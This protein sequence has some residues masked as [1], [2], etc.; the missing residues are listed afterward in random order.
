MRLRSLLCLI[1]SVSATV[2]LAADRPFTVGVCAH[3]GQHKGYLPGNLSLMKQAGIVSFRDE[4]GWRS[5]ERVKGQLQMPPEYE[6][7]ISE[8]VRRGLEPMLILDYGNPF[9]D[10]GDKPLS[11]EAV[12]AFVRYSEFVV[13]HFRGK[14]RHYEVWNEWDIGIG[15]TTPGS[16]ETYAKLLAA[17]YPRIKKADPSI[18]VYGGAMTPGGIRNGW[19]ERMLKAGAL[20]SLDQVSIH[21]YNYSASGRERSPEAWAGWMREVQSL[22]SKYADGK[23]YP[24]VVTEMG[25]PTQVDRRGTPPAVSG[26]Y[27]AR[28]Y[29]LGR[30]VPTL[31]GIWWYDFQDDGWQ[32]K[33]NEDNFGIVRPDLTPKPGYF[34]LADVSNVVGWGAY[35]GR[36]ETKDPDIWALRFRTPDG[37]D[38]LAVWSVHEDDGWQIVLRNTG[39]L[40]PV[41]MKEVGGGSVNRSWGA[42]SWGDSRTVAAVPDELHLVVRGTPWLISGDLAG[43]TIS[44]VKKREQPEGMR[45]AVFLQ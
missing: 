37:K 39:K 32:P 4:L 41:V 26:D 9:Y 2:T 43:V 27:L 10:N 19:L 7:F 15:G 34:A 22:I 8:A 29:L 5:L 35:L 25:W 11:A 1:A 36:I 16:A 30:T 12:E 20:K 17:V 33:Y 44:E 40:A 14:V 23:E 38:V 21:T 24:L 42:R 6:H 18:I 45:G 3:F 31:K 13:G 28:M